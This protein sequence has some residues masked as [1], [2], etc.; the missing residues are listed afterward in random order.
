MSKGANW[1]LK[2]LGAIAI[3]ASLLAGYGYWQAR[4]MGFFRDPVFETARPQLPRL[5][6]PSVLVFSKT[7]SFI[8]KDAI[9]AARVLLQDLGAEKGW[10]V[11]A[12]DSGAVFNQED[13]AHFAVVVWNNVTGDVLLPEQREAFRTWMEG[14]GG[15][16]GLHAAGDNSHAVWP[17]Y[18]DAVIR[19]RFIGHPMNPQFQQARLDVEL[20]SDPIVAGLPD[21]WV[22][23]DEWYSFAGSPRAPDLR[24]LVTIDESSYAPRSFFGQ[25]LAMG[26]DHPI[27]WKHCVGRGRVFYAA[28]GHTAETYAEPEYRALLERAISWA[29]RIGVQ[30]PVSEPLDCEP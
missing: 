25:A 20:P 13:L 26:S 11:Y 10:S 8:H 18:L 9:P 12:T 3:L 7:N 19:A 4:S 17:W 23:T 5:E 27:I 28:P 14:G 29:G 15:Y 30:A 21:P 22:R 24:V 16:V 2:V 1:F 6:G